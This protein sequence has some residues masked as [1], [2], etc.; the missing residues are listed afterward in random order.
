MKKLFLS[1]AV[2]ASVSLFSCGNK[3]EKDAAA[4]DA[5]AT[6]VVEETV[7]AVDTCCSDTCAQDSC[8]AQV[9]EAAVAQD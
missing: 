9:E 4:E 6:E 7:V 3:A 5:A 1:I 8:V 2:I